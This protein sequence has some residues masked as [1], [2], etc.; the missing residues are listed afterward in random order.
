[1]IAFGV[2]KAISLV[3]TVII[4]DVFGVGREWDAFVTANSVPEL[5]F[6][7]IA[8]GALANAFIPIFSGYLAREDRTGAWKTASHVINTVFLATLI[9][10]VIAFFAAPAL[11]RGFVAP[12]FLPA[13]QAETVELMRILLIS[14]LIFSI[15]GIMMGILQ[16]YNRFLLPALAPILFDVGILFGVIFL[17][18]RFGVYGIAY[19]A[20]IGAALHLAIQIPGVIR[21]RAKW[22]PELGLRDPQL[23]RII[24]LMLP[25]VV[26]LFFFS[27]SFLVMNSIAS[28]LGEGA[29]SALSW[30]WRLMQ[31]P[32][33][34]I[35]TAMGVVI[36]P[37]LSAYSALN[38]LKGKR[39]AMSGA[40][41]FILIATIPSSIGLIVVGRPLI[42]LLEGGAFDTSATLLV[43]S[44]LQ[45]FT[46]GLI[47]Q[48]VL[49]VAARSFYADKDT[50][51][52]LIA[53]FVGGV[54]N[55]GLA[56]A[57]SDVAGV[58]RLGFYNRVAADF[59]SLGLPVSM[60]NVGGLA[61]AQSLGFCIEVAILL[62]ILRRRWQGL[63]ERSLV[64]TF[65]KALAASLIM[66][67]VILAVDLVFNALD[68]FGRGR[69]FTA[70]L[71][72][73]EVLIGGIAFVATALV[74]K[75]QEVRDVWGLIIRR[76]R[77]TEAAT[78]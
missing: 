50:I 72:G 14:T 68:L 69:I 8:G 56:F 31:I 15:S 13:A 61:L 73:S 2:A 75:M 19:G 1:M 21:V 48:S 74:L 35:G 17:T 16:S 71:V 57:L 45:F 70:V 11:V 33:T 28:R 18:D 26:G 22:F 46:I 12:G 55:I 37:T 51:I 66:A 44:T 34:L 62:V 29:V 32:E 59:P 36:L 6:T 54:I 30:G 77:R 65:A 27:F 4:A 3:Q 63:N 9:I 49:E 60:G 25:L 78:V 41:R 40:I 24:R 67:L 43:Y 38:N 7:L 52:P 42:S 20:V 76:V 58:E 53:S 47:A 10:S 64:V 23:W 5:I 39:D